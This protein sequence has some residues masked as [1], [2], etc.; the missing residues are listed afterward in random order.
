MFLI[1]LTGGISAGKST[2]ADHWQ[3]LGAVHL[4]ADAIARQVVAAGTP[5]LASVA[6]A[7]GPAVLTDDGSLDRAALAK[8]VFDNP[9]LRQRLESIVHPLVQAETRRLLEH[10]PEDA[11]VVYNVP[12][13]VEANVSLPFDRIVTVEAPVDE[14]IKRMMAIRGMTLEEA[15]SRIRNQASPAQRANAAEFILS[16]NQSLELLLKD[17]GKLWL[18]F[19]REA[20]AKRRSNT[21]D[22]AENGGEGSN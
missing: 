7:F 17:A 15:Q 3:Y 6:E 20:E 13:L 11:L 4:D 1:G 22:K 16:S 18:Q 5:G 8:L 9:E 14:Q 21:G 2:V 19:E 12:L 10:Q